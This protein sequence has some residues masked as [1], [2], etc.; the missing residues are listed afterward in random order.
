[1]EG[2]IRN[3]QGDEPEISDLK[4]LFVSCHLPCPVRMGAHHR[5][6]NIGRALKK[7]GKVT[8]VFVGIDNTRESREETQREFDEVVIMPAPRRPRS[9]LWQEL[10][11]KFSYHWPYTYAE[12]V[13]RGDRGK[14]GQLLKAHDLVWFHTATA[15][16]RLGIGRQ[17]RSILDLDDLNQNKYEMKYRHSEGVRLKLAHRL[18]G[19]KWRRRERAALKQYDVI[20][21]CS[22]ADKEFLGGGEQ[23]FVVPNG[24]V[25]PE[26]RSKYKRSGEYR[27]GFI[28]ELGYGPNSDGLE[29][30]GQHVWPLVRQKIPEAC[31]RVVGRVPGDASFLNYPGF[32]P[33]GFLPEV[34]EEFSTWS[35]MIVPLRYGGGTRIKIIEAFS[36]NCPVISTGQGAY[37]LEVR[38]LED[39]KFGCELAE[40]GWKL[41]QAKYTWEVIGES[42]REAVREC[43][44][45]PGDETIGCAGMKQDR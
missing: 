38:L 43:V 16:D 25:G 26:E 21:V 27:L 37:G 39:R 29:W 22:H 34:S 41:F 23:L 18:L 12:K 30:F 31:L 40:A 33:L 19:Y 4:I 7:C 17:R 28:G 35:G 13:R 20:T 8:F 32:E 44:S 45:Q 5:I 15:A 24:F 10:R 11:W 3:Q 1:M 14:F 42:I 36:R 6:L 9:N 2:T